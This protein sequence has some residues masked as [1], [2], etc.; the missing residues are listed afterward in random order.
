MIQKV[1]VIKIEENYAVVRVRKTSACKDNCAVCGLC[2][3]DKSRDVKVYN[4]IG[5]KAGDTAYAVLESGKTI[6]L[7]FIT[8]TLPIILMAVIYEVTNN[9]TFAALSLIPLFI[10]SAFFGNFLSKKKMFMSYLKEYKN[11]D[12][13]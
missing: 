9:G 5:A 11:E 8:F 1:N 4:G 2:D 7:A 13:L 10:L 12:D 6:T 3:A